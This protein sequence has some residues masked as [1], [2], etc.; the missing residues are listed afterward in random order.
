MCTA[1]F[2]DARAQ[3]LIPRGPELSFIK[4]GRSVAACPHHTIFSNAIRGSPMC[5]ELTGSRASPPFDYTGMFLDDRERTEKE[6]IANQR[7]ARPDDRDDWRRD[8]ADSRSDGGNRTRGGGRSESAEKGRGGGGS[9]PGRGQSEPDY[10]LAV[11][12][13]PEPATLALVASGII[14]LA[15]FRRRRSNGHDG[16]NN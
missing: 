3:N 9:P 8:I 1:A 6:R 2:A 16:I 12:A 14:A 15:A 7:W 4:P 10:A 11:T 13:T 5:A